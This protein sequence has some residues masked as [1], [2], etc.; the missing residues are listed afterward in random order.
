MNWFKAHHGI[1]T[2]PKWRLIAARSGKPVSAVVCVWLY[3]LDRASQAD[4][5]GSIDGLDPELVDMVYEFEA[6]TAEAIMKA[7]VSKGLIEDGR[8]AAW[9]RHQAL[10][11]DER[12]PM[13]STERSR[14]FRA[15]RKEAEAATAGNEMQRDATPALQSNEA[16]RCNAID[17]IRI[18]EIREEKTHKEE[19]CVSVPN[20]YSPE[21]IEEAKDSIRR[22]ADAEREEFEQLREAYKPVRDDGPMAGWPEYQQVRRSKGWPGLLFVL[23]RLQTLI[24]QDDQWR[25]GYKEGL[26]RFLTDRMWEMEP[27]K[28]A[29]DPNAEPEKTAEDKALDERIAKMRAEMKAKEAARKKALRGW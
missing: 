21:D 23:D 15:A 3:I 7:F 29:P 24:E 16:Q 1:S 19:A 13:T 5:R 17:K 27:R 2:N 11:A 22:E 20:F 25:R 18:E 4:E 14:K 9:D 10:P 28:A 8:V 6:G 12:R 26:R